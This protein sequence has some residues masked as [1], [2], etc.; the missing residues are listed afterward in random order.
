MNGLCF[1]SDAEGGSPLVGQSTALC[2]LF[3]YRDLASTLSTEDRIMIQKIL[4]E[5]FLGFHVRIARLEI[6]FMFF[7][8]L[9]ICDTV[10]QDVRTEDD[11]NPGSRQAHGGSA[12]LFLLA[13]S[14]RA[15]ALAQL[16]GQSRVLKI[17]T[18]SLL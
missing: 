1:V 6:N 18:C 9:L 16:Q 15:A 10:W 7:C 5:G 13:D 12:Q 14:L 17:K 2:D 8:A 3:I 11:W 4:T